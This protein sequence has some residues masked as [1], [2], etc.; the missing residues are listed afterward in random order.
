MR[1]IL[2]RLPS[3]SSINEGQYYETTLGIIF[4]RGKKLYLSTLSFS[5]F[6]YAYVKA[7][8]FPADFTNLPDTEQIRIRDAL[9]RKR[10]GVTNTRLA[11][12]LKRRQNPS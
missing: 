7:T 2:C 10:S 6:S 12:E 5:Q 4:R 3:D 1:S 8:F 11:L 9:E